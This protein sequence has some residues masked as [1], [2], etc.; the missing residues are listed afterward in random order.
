LIGIAAGMRMT[1]QSGSAMTILAEAEPLARAPGCEI[2]AAQIH[3]LRGSLYFPMGNVAACLKEHQQALELARR[4]GSVE[5]EARA[6]S[7]LG[8]AHYAGSRPVSSYQYFEQCVALSRAHG[9]GKVEVANLAMLGVSNVFF[10]MRL[11]EGLALSQAALDLGVKV[12]HHRSQIIA[13]QGCAWA[14]LEMGEWQRARPHADAAVELSRSS[15]ARRFVPESMAFV[16][17]CL[18]QEGKTDEAV[19]MLREALA[20]STDLLTYFGPPILASLA[21]LTS[22]ADERQRCLDQAQRICESGC[23][24]HNHVF[25]Y[26]QA[27]ELCLKACEWN[28]AERYV[29]ALDSLFRE[30]AVPVATFIAERARAL[31]AAGRGGR[32]PALLASLESLARKARDARSVIWAG[33]LDEAAK[34]MRPQA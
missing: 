30:E 34:R 11:E 12:D 3:Y 21:E 26:R 17:H 8:D 5:W 14:R 23:P 19:P 31:I 1:D 25:F 16:A 10:L 13:H 22:D 28:T 15:G 27:I 24:V 6:L 32:D 9:L 4:A 33:A 18:A 7:G 2:E 20:L 29:E